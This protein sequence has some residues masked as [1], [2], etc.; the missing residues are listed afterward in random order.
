MTDRLFEPILLVAVSMLA[1]PGAV[2]A[3]DSVPR[4]IEQRV[5][6]LRDAG[7]LVI[8]GATVRNRRVLGDVYE[9]S[10]FAPLWTDAS[11]ARQ[12]FEALRTTSADGLDPADY[13][14]AAIDSLTRM[15]PGAVT[16]AELD[17][18]R[19]DALMRV[20]SGSDKNWHVITSPRW[21]AAKYSSFIHSGPC[22]STVGETM[23]TPEPKAV[24]GGTS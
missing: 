3:Q 13:N 6:L 24:C 8:A 15:P 23:P 2:R 10:S 22:S 11:V 12:L 17:L 19:T 5:E 14:V 7:K 20:T 4:E 18:L 9:A 1:A 21:I 16:I